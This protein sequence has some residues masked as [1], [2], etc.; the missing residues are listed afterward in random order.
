[1]RSRLHFSIATSLRPKTLLIDEALAV[2][3]REFKRKSEARLEELRAE[4]SALVV[5]SH[6]L[7]EIA[8]MCSRS[9]WLQNGKIL[10][11]G[12]TEDVIEAYEA[13]T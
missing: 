8:R 12:A 4:A 2:G 3:D 13:A 9:I 5:V 7:R 10:Q 11:D 6:N 1:M